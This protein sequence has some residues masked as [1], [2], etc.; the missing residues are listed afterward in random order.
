MDATTEARQP[1]RVTEFAFVDP[2]LM[3]LNLFRPLPRRGRHDARRRMFEVEA[4][5]DGRRLRVVGPYTLGADDLSVLLAVLAL[6]GLLGKV[7]EAAASEAS[8]VAIVDGLESRGEVVDAVHIR[9]RTTLYAVCREAGVSVNGGSYE[10]VSECLWRMAA[11]SYADLG[12]VE[13]NARRM[14]MSGS[15][16][17]LSAA[18]DEA[19]GEVTVVVNAR[20]AGVLLGPPYGRIDLT[21]ARSLGEMARLLHLRLSV[22][23]R[24]GRA[25]TVTT[26]QLGEWVYGGPSAS[27][28]EAR[29]RREEVRHGMEELGRLPGW[30]LSENRRRLMVSVSRPAAGG[31]REPGCAPPCKEHAAAGRGPVAAPG[32]ACA[33]A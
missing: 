5:H 26:D 28:R 9:V 31:S 22:M 12:P 27:G 30:E 23:I 29:R 6:A 21:E 32:G 3:G 2:G 4:V 10:R 1:A 7:I 14:R 19:T 11:M 16:R 25:L 18:T 24:R 20:F 8:R 15:Q 33:D 13:A 17:L